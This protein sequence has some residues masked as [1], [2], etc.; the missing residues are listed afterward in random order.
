ML[1]LLDP[2]AQLLAH[3]VPQRDARARRLAVL[4]RVELGVAFERARVREEE[5][6]RGGL[7]LMS[8]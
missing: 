4:L 5:G 7:V 3:E 2:D 8:K 6:L 1:A